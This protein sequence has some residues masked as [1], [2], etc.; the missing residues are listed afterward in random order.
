M[1]AFSSRVSVVSD[2]TKISERGFL[3]GS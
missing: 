2:V 1:A 3:P